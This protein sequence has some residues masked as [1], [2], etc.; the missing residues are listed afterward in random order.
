MVALWA[1]ELS[2]YLKLRELEFAPAIRTAEK[3]NLDRSAPALQRRSND[4]YVRVD[5]RQSAQPPDTNDG[6][7]Q[8][9]AVAALSL[10]PAR[11]N[12]LLGPWPALGAK[13]LSILLIGGSHLLQTAL[14]ANEV[15]MAFVGSRRNET[16]VDEVAYARQKHRA[17][18]NQKGPIHFPM[19]LPFRE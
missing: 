8:V 5:E 13:D 1:G 7:K 4:G 15:A 6:E 17:S 19:S 2:A 3:V 16:G 14:A 12:H 18:A 9:L 10:R 11:V